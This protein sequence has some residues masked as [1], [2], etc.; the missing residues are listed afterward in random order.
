M[1][2]DDLPHGTL[3]CVPPPPDPSSL[4]APSALPL[5]SHAPPSYPPPSP[6]LGSGGPALT[7]DVRS[8]PRRTCPTNP[9]RS[10]QPRPAAH[11]RLRGRSSAPD[12]SVWASRPFVGQAAQEPPV[13]PCS[14]PPSPSPNSPVAVHR[15][16][17][18]AGSL[19]PSFRSRFARSPHPPGPD[20][21]AHA[22]A[23]GGRGGGSPSTSARCSSPSIGALA[24][25]FSLVLPKTRPS[26][27]LSLALGQMTRV[28]GAWPASFLVLSGL[29]GARRAPPPPALARP[30]ALLAPSFDA[31][32]LLLLLLLPSSSPCRPPPTPPHAHPARPQT[33]GDACPR[34]RPAHL[35]R[36]RARRPRRGSAPTPPGARLPAARPPSSFGPPFPETPPPLPSPPRAPSFLSRAQAGSM[37]LGGRVCQGP[38]PDRR[39]ERRPK[40]SA[41]QLAGLRALGRRHRARSLCDGRSRPSP[42]HQHTETGTPL[43][44]PPPTPPALPPPPVWE[45]GLIRCS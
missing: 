37:A 5:A 39:V 35:A 32:S 6:R 42:T 19:H 13:G 22:P 24:S 25:R 44:S 29:L 30:P 3:P 28:V 23:P 16:H 27:R 40:V 7:G 10:S 41:G 11:A 36:L 21:H 31:P 8:P 2:P 26:A 14:P 4:S 17:S 34:P 1:L 38:R 12:A 15:R 33:G 43:A 9:S 18:L 45:G 20:A